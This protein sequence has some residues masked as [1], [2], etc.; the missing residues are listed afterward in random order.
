[1]TTWFDKAEEVFEEFDI[2]A[3]YYEQTDWAYFECEFC[4]D[5][6]EDFIFVLGATSKDAF[7]ESL[8]NYYQEFDPEEHAAFWYGMNRGEPKSLRRLLSDADSIDE[9]LEDLTISMTAKL[10]AA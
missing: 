6:G 9:M 5:A 7:I 4:S 1:M 10:R 2:S 8:R 3:N